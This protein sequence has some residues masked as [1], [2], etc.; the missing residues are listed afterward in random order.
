MAGYANK[1]IKLSFDEYSED[2][3]NDP[4]WIVIRNPKLVPPGELQTDVALTEDGQVADQDEAIRSMH[5]NLAKL[6]KGWRVYDAGQDVQLDPVTGAEVGEPPTLLPLPA[7]PEL[8]ARLP[9]EFVTRIA[10]EVQQAVNPQ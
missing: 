1:L 2:P 8:V 10:R 4:I 5:K 9:M 6:I 7:T 3:V